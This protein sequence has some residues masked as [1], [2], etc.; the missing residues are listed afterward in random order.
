VTDPKW[1]K[2]NGF[3]VL[4]LKNGLYSQF[5]LALAK[6]NGTTPSN[7]FR[8]LLRWQGQAA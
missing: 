5:C 6:L 7:M 2:K 8:R 1:L 4:P 3:P